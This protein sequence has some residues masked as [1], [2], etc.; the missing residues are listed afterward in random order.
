MFLHVRNFG[1]LR[2]APRLPSDAEI[3][4]P[5]EDAIGADQSD[6]E[7]HASQALVHHA[8]EHFREPIIGCG[9]DAEDGGYT[10]DQVEVADHEVGVMQRDIK[11][12]LRQKRAAQSTG[13]KQ[14][15]EA[16]GEEHRCLETDASAF[17]C[18]Q[19]VESLDG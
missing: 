3:V 5:H 1:E 9:E 12:R 11:D 17:E 16:D 8:A 18:A 6:E 7:V 4:H 15:Y 14:G 13:Y 19:P 10:H 2:I